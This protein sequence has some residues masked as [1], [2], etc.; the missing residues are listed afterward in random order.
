MHA[1][2]QQQ[3]Q[4]A[5]AVARQQGVLLHVE[6][7]AAAWLAAAG[8]SA[9]AG[10]RPLRQLVKRHVLVPLA[11]CIMQEAGTAASGSLSDLRQQH[12]VQQSSS[13]KADLA[14]LDSAMAAALAGAGV[15]TTGAWGV[16]ILQCVQRGGAAAGGSAEHA[17]DLR[18]ARLKRYL[19]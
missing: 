18:F 6:P 12:D 17:L 8:C 10:A 15:D 4:Q 13:P 9:T 14:E 1:I 7:A 3:L 2:V 11:A 19:H 16:A 5:S